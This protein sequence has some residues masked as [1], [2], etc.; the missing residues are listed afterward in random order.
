MI[1]IK[2]KRLRLVPIELKYAKEL[3]VLW[4]DYE[5]VKYTHNPWCKTVQECEARIQ[6]IQQFID[7]LH[8]NNWVI[9]YGEQVIG[10]AGVPTISHEKG[11]YALY[12]Q[13]CKKEWGKGF[14]FEV[15]KTLVDELFQNTEATLLIAD[16]ITV[17]LASMKIL[18]KV[19]MERTYLEEEGFKREDLVEDI[20]NY[21]LTR[22]MWENTIEL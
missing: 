17:N 19:G 15:A 7:S 2:T 21:R 22:Q 9:L 8:M 3:L 6:H 10:V 4:S 18:E 12:Y 11:E 20:M 14:G 1:T 13:L 16:A 5:V